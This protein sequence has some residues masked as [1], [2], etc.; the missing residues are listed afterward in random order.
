MDEF[1]TEVPYYDIIILDE[2]EGILNQLCSPTMNGQAC[3]IYKYLVNII[4]N[5]KKLIVLDGD[6]SSRTHNFIKQFGPSTT[7]NLI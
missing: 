5:C 4:L 6:I 3:E 7:D 1:T 2:I